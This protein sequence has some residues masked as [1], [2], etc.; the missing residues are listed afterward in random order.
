MSQTKKSAPASKK[1]KP[2][3]DL[4]AEQPTAK[5]APKEPKK[6]SAKDANLDTETN[7]NTSFANMSPDILADHLAAQ[8]K[9]IQDDLSLLELEEKRIPVVAI[10]DT[11]EFVHA[12]MLDHMTDFLR[13]YSTPRRDVSELI[14]AAKDKGSPHTIVVTGAGLRAADVTRVMRVFQTKDATVMKL[15]AKHIKLKDAKEHVAK[16]RM[17]IGV[18][19]PKRISDLLEDGALSSTKLERLIIDVSH[20]DEKK[21]GILDMKDLQPPLMDLLNRPEL[22]DRYTGDKRGIELLF[23]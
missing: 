16:T 12:R 8:T 7:I 2:I 10:R 1:R 18:G 19:T 11:T 3:D 23:Y 9:R 15:F 20:I 14:R 22:K 6:P 5:R 21:R 4:D 17:N 13:G